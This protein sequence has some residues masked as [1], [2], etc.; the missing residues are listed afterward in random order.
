MSLEQ[1]L[2]AVLKAEAGTRVR[3]TSIQSA[4]CAY[5]EMFEDKIVVTKDGANATSQLA[6]SEFRLS[7]VAQGQGEMAEGHHSVGVTGA[8]DCLFTHQ[9]I[10][11]MSEDA[12]KL[13]VDLLK[14]PKISGGL[15]TLI[16]SPAIVGL[17]S[18]EAIGHTV[19]G[20]LRALRLRGRGKARH[21]CREPAGHAVRRCGRVEGEPN[22]G[23][24]LLVDDEGVLAE[25]T[26]IIDQGK[27]VSYLHN[28]ESAALYGVAPTGNGRAW[29][30][31]DEPLI[32]MRN[33]YIKPGTQ[34]L[35][36]IIA[37]TKDGYL[38]DCP[39]GGQ[40]D[41]TGEFMFGAQKVYADRERKAHQALPR[42]HHL[43][44][45]VSSFIDGGRGLARVSA[46]SRLGLLRQ[47]TAGEGGRGWPFHPVQGDHRRDAGVTPTLKKERQAL[48]DAAAKLIQLAL[49]GGA[50]SAEVCG[51][52]NQRTKITLEKQDYHM[53]SAD[54]GFSLGLRVLK[55]QKQGFAS[56]NTTDAAELKEV[57]LRAV[58]IA[59]FS[60]ENP[61]AVIAPSENLPKEA[62]ATLWDDALF[63]LSV[64]TQKDWTKVMVDEALR[65]PRFR[66]ERGL[67]FDRLRHVPRDELPGHP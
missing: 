47:G 4:S 49:S 37:S 6:R 39:L 40:A 28:R 38:V 34:S 24:D 66:N 5:S 55:G 27:L 25:T 58:E 52:Y 17:L 67:G 56:C 51:S 53:A 63:G 29:L 19:G 13:A 42:R 26:T 7:A 1:K 61:H 62:P 12:A 33:T 43:G 23:G 22:A 15:S 48:E 20:R 30:Y 2:D 9:S 8:W 57:A 46:G 11:Q 32:R 14:A 3:S 31:S 16:L 44:P 21:R 41:A 35:D 64:Q 65:D 10:A 54:D 59:G 60:P 36:E 50:T 45:G 18:H